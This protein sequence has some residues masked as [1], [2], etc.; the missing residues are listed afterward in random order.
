MENK[1]ILLLLLFSISETFFIALTSFVCGYCIGYYFYELVRPRRRAEGEIVIFFKIQWKTWIREKMNLE[2][3][4]LIEEYY[5][6]DNL[7]NEQ[8]FLEDAKR[9]IEEIFDLTNCS[10]YYWKKNDDFFC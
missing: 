4:N 8:D 10:F 6:G 1:I 5:F 7:S 9:K 2:K 3:M